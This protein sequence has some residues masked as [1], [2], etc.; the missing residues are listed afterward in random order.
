MSQDF[1]DSDWCRS[2]FVIIM[3]PEETLQNISEYMEMFKHKSYLEVEDPDKFHKIAEYSSS[4]KKPEADGDDDLTD[5][6]DDHEF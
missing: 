6:N 4:V 3:Q 5:K 1:V 2:E